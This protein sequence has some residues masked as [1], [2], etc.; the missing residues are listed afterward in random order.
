MPSLPCPL[1][2]RCTDGVDGMTWESVD[3]DFD[4]ARKLVA[5]HVKA[6]HQASHVIVGQ[7]I[8][9]AETNPYIQRHIIDNQDNQ[10][11]RTLGR[12]NAPVSVRCPYCKTQITTEATTVVG[13][14]SRSWKNSWFCA[15]LPFCTLCCCFWH[16]FCIH[17]FKD[18]N[19]KCPNC[20][21]TL[22]GYQLSP[23]GKTQ[24]LF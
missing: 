23:L 1:G 7:R 14:R 2:T 19:H 6:A 10:L 13:V 5:D 16:L 21:R 18:I 9:S 24:N 22:G 3:V 4:Q 11:T 15:L 8:I 17:Q 12:A 20:E